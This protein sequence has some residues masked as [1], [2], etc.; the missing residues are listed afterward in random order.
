MEVRLA[1]GEAGA[2]ALETI[3]S[4][5]GVPVER[6][7]DLSERAA[8]VVDHDRIDLPDTARWDIYSGFA[9]EQLLLVML[10]MADRNSFKVVV[11][12]TGHAYNVFGTNRVS[13]HSVG[14]AVD[15]YAIGT[16]AGDEL[17]IDSHDPSSV[18]Y[19][20]S[21]WIV[22]RYDIREYGSPWKFPDGVAH[23]FTNQVHHDHV[24][25]GV[26]PYFTSP[27][28]PPTTTAPPTTTTTVAAEQ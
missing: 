17:V 1:R 23:T 8:A 15:I 25:V 26:Q 5:G 19:E 4:S 3:A 24:H 7:D 16:D 13:N 28:P 22:S 18:L 27:D 20:L 6:P 14:R 10:D 12:S 11:L 9:N 2:W 21:E